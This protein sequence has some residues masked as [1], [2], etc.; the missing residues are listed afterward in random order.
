MSRRQVKTLLSEDIAHAR[1]MTKDA[2]CAM[3]QSII[4]EWQAAWNR[5]K[6]TNVESRGEAIPIAP[7]PARRFGLP[8]F[9][10]TSSLLKTDKTSI[11]V[12]FT[13]LQLIGKNLHYLHAKNMI[14]SCYTR[15]LMSEWQPLLSFLLLKSSLTS[16]P[17]VIHAIIWRCFQALLRS[18]SHWTRFQQVPMAIPPSTLMQC[19]VM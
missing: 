18:Q 5:C 4:N 2:D 1:F 8:P 12:A 13:I 11:H 14:K 17:E 7:L 16:A 15:V 9:C 6:K 3:S 19:P 10:E